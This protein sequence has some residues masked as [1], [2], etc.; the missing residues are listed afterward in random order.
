MP[1]LSK[2]VDRKGVQSRFMVAITNR[3]LSDTWLLAIKLSSIEFKNRIFFEV[4]KFTKFLKAGFL[5][6]LV[7]KT[8]LNA[9]T[10]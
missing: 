3:G 10:F 8:T 6:N 9:L 4:A 2:C 7:Y 1:V 5:A